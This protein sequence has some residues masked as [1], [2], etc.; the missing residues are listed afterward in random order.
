MPDASAF[1][2][3]LLAKAGITVGGT[4]P[5]DIHVHDERVWER[6]LRDRELGLGESYIEGWWD[7]EALDE[8]LTRIIESDLKA[9]I[10]PG[11]DL[12]VM[13]ARARLTNRQSI[14]RAKQNAVAH[15]NIGN[16]LYERMLD[17]RMIYTCAYWD[18]A[19]TLD[20]AQEAKLDLI[21]RK[22][23]MEPGMRVLDIG[24]GWG[25]F[26]QYAA[27]HYG[28]VGTGVSPASAQVEMAH[29]RLRGLD[30]EVIEADYREIT[31]SYDRIVSIGMF[32]HVGAKNYARFFETCDRVLAPG[33]MMLHHTIGGLESRTKGDPWIDKYIFPG[34]QLP[35]LAQIGAATENTWVIEDVHNFGP[36]YDRTVMAWLANIEAS[37]EEIPHYDESFRR[38]WRYYL[39]ISAAGF[40]ARNTQ[41]WQLVFR[42]ANHRSA[43]YR[44]VR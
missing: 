20:Q 35:S 5:W 23:G 21:C 43:S 12:L 10:R 37:W 3:A 17:K 19:V 42:R 28:V 11:R 32:E 30:I 39:Q 34:G 29:E 16:D 33:G 31:G 24:C 36:D 13:A 2:R 25:G 9:E 8:A 26:L 44:A 1:G 38:M 4:K 6:V 41:L 18:S 15:Y 27:E 7:C 22:L 14:D 40:R